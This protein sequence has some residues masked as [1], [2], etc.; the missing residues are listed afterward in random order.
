M[1]NTSGGPFWNPPTALPIPNATGPYCSSWEARGRFLHLISQSPS[2]EKPTPARRRSYSLSTWSSL[3]AKPYKIGPSEGSRG[4]STTTTTTEWIPQTGRSTRR[5]SQ[6]PLERRAPLPP[7]GLM[8]SS[9]FTSAILVLMALP[10]CQSSS[11]SLLPYLTSR[12]SGITPSLSK[13]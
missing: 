1:G 5:A 11:T 7:R 4:T 12:Q 3:P 13:S 2:M 9:C 6:Q 8:G 10:S